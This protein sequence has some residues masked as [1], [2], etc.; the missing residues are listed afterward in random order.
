MIIEAAETALPHLFLRGFRAPVG[1]KVAHVPG[2]PA[3]PAD[4][5]TTF[6]EVG[7]FV[8]RAR[9][10]FAGAAL[11]PGEVATEDQP[12]DGAPAAGPFRHE[13]DI[14]V[15]KP[16]PDVVVV[17]AITAIA[18]V[19]NDPALAPLPP[20][21]WGDALA[22]EID[23]VLVAAP[24]GTVEID[25]GAGFGP[26]A[27]LNFGWLPRGTPPRLALAGDAATNDPWQ[28]NKFKADQFKLPAGYDNAFLN[29]RPLAGQQ[30]F[31]PG[32]RLRFTDTTPAGPD[33]VTIVTIPAAPVLA[34]T[35]DG[36]A[37]DPPLLLSPRADTVVMD[38]GAQEFLIL[39]RATFPWDARYETA[40]LEVS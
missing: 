32:D 15:W 14:P 25:R 30:A 6:Q 19:V 4:D 24:F 20:P 1:Q 39:W 8:A 17:D 2:D 11:D 22:A 40:T 33:V 37:L 34:V 21:P 28:L 12:Y 5:A 35:Q 38:R 18:A 31:A 26:A 3:D 36:A 16:D 13:A 27:A 29:G 9:L 10:S 7:A 23:A